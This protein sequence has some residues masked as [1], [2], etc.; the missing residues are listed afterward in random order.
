M[1][2]ITLPGTDITSSVISFG[3]IFFGTKINQ[4][5]SFALLDTYVDLGGNLIDTARVYA[6]WLPGEKHMSEKTIGHWLHARNHRDKVLIATKGMHPE[7]ETMDV[8][9]SSRRDI[10]SDLDESLRYLQT[11]Y[12]D[13]YWLHRDD[14]SKPAGEILETL[15]EL[16]K[17]GKIRY[18]GCSW[19]RLERIAEAVDYAN[20]HGIQGF[21]GNQMN[22]SLAVPRRF[23]NNNGEQTSSGLDV[24]DMNDRHTFDFHLRHRMSF[25]AW[26]SQ[27]KG[28]FSKM[29]GRDPAALR[30]REQQLYCTE[31]NMRRLKRAEQ[32]ARKWNRPVSQIALAYLTSQK[33]PVIPII[34]C[35][36]PQ[37][38]EE[39]MGSNDL[40]LSEATL[41]YLLSGNGEVDG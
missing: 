22:W 31:E 17:E 2:T 40:I 41:D 24:I 37:Q 7:L 14:E 12:V 3:S 34:G 21:H 25:F 26:S 23:W 1:R 15:N 29:A 4:A 28:F 16:V 13:F 33:L 38:L 20:K 27:A 6:D 5:D 19:W 36:T 32:V 18:F 30:E 8:P 35:S 9:R 39:N 11:D 10:R